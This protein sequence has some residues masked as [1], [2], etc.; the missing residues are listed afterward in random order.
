M[1]TKTDISVIEGKKPDGTVRLTFTG[2][3]VHAT[4][5]VCIAENGT[6][7]LHEQPALRVPRLI[8]HFETLNISGNELR[9][10]CAVYGPCVPGTGAIEMH[11]PTTRGTQVVGYDPLIV[12]SDAVQGDEADVVL[13]LLDLAVQQCF[14]FTAI[15]DLMIERLTHEIAYARAS[16]TVQEIALARLESS[17]PHTGP[18][19]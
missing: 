12:D 13:E 4:A 10:M 7:A 15:K 2:E 8:L 6:V 17:Q 1:A 11:V 18:S 9:R 19:R 3:L 14:T 16:L 5:T